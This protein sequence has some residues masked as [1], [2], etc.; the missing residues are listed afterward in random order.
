M[1]VD[2]IILVILMLYFK[3]F[4][5]EVTLVCLVGRVIFNGFTMLILLKDLNHELLKLKKGFRLFYSLLFIPQHHYYVLFIQHLYF[6][7]FIP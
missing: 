6:L 4:G 5:H 3:G 2:L 7:K 1:N